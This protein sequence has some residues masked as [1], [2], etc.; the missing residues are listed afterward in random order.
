M[1]GVRVPRGIMSRS[2]HKHDPNNRGGAMFLDRSDVAHFGSR[3]PAKFL[4]HV[5]WCGRQGVINLSA[6][7]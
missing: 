4:S 5:T 6:L 1:G 2:V 7:C 3:L